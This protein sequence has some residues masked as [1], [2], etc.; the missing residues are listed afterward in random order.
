MSVLRASLIFC[1]LLGGCGYQLR[2]S[3]YWASMPSLAI[4]DGAQPSLKA[5]QEALVSSVRVG[6]LSE[7]TYTVEL[8]DETYQ[9]WP[10]AASPLDAVINYRV[11]LRWSVEVF[12]PEGQ[13]VLSQSAETADRFV[14]QRS[15]LL[16]AGEAEERR[17]NQLRNTLG[18]QLVRQ[19][20]Q[21]LANMAVSLQTR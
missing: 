21:R 3:D 17:L 16:A 9:K 8:I 12:G 1:L 11:T 18:D 2:G 20:G 7:P 10:I 6:P 5:A 15:N 4:A 19:I 13:W 14:E